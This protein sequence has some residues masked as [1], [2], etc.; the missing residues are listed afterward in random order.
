MPIFHVSSTFRISLP[1]NAHFWLPTAFHCPKIPIF[2]L[3]THFTFQPHVTAQK[4]LFSTAN[5]I[6]G[7]KMPIFHVSSTFRISLPKTAHFWLPTAFHCPKIPITAFHCPEKFIF[8][9]QPHFRPTNAHFSCL[10]HI[11]H[12]IAQKCSFLTA[13]PHFTAQKYPFFIDQKHF[14]CHC[15][16]R[17]IFYCQPHFRP[18]NTHF[19]SP[20]HISLPK[21]A[22]FRL[23]TSFH[24]PKIPIFHRPKA[25]CISLPKAKVNK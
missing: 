8:D 15:Q 11:S 23:P 22:Y 21:N 9:C 5:R 6:S 14:A 2:H 13:K 17:L 3:P 10:K 18:K 12:F 25:F 19:S 7:L 24:C 4:C 1:K 16:R 20:N